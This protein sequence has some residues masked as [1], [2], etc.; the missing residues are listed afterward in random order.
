MNVKLSL[1]LKNGLSY[2][3]IL[4]YQKVFKNLK[5][6]HGPTYLSYKLTEQ[7]SDQVL[8]NM[9]TTSYNFIKGTGSLAH[10]NDTDKLT[11]K[12][13]INCYIHT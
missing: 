5:V 11:T 1:K 9:E 7:L 2:L 8:K 10:N 3:F 12:L 4:Y 13:N 6:V